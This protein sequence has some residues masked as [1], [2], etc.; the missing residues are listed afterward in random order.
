MS[1]LPKLEGSDRDD[2]RARPRTAIRIKGDIQA[3]CFLKFP[4]RDMLPGATRKR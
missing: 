2:N 4:L 1:G 3:V